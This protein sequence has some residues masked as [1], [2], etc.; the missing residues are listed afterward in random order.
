VISPSIRKWFAAGS[1]AGIEISGAPGSESLHITAVRVRPSGARVLGQFTIENFPQQPAGVWGTDYAAFLRKLGISHVAATVLLPRRDVIVRTLA[2]PGVSDKDLEAAIQFQLDGLHPYNEE[3]AM[4]SWARVEGSN[5]VLIAIARK[6]VVERYATL[7]AEAGIKIAAFT[8]SAAAIHSALRI[9]GRKPAGDVL[10][11]SDAGGR[12]EIYGESA[13]RPVFSA[14]FDGDLDRA[15]SL[16]ASELRVAGEQATSAQ[17]IEELVGA[18][19]ALPF[20][21]ALSSACPSLTMAVNLLSAD[22]R[23]TSSRALWIPSA[24]LGAIA[25]ILAGAVAAFPRFEDRRYLHELQRQIA[26][27]APQEKRAAAVDR[28][29]AATRRRTALL[30]ELKGRAKA[31]MDALAELTRIM[32]PPTW[33]NVLELSPTQ[34]SMAGEANQAEPLLKLIDSSP[35]FKGTEFTMA[36]VHQQNGEVFRLK[37]NRIGVAPQPEGRK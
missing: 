5:A 9:F 25:L 24:A 1:G 21:A 17:R 4:A 35:M 7:F 28:E 23:Q 30:D 32:Q 34:V 6:Q 22:Q 37:T 20:A 3:D 33:L 27:L 29:V 8:C 36:P 19:P 14:A 11:W 16:A 12:I 31:D 2:L 10:A 15:V 13:A 18:T 26:G